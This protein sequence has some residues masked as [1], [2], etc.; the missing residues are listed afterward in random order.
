MIMEMCEFDLVLDFDRR[1]VCS[2]SVVVSS[3]GFAV[4]G[5]GG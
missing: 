5:K 1:M 3:L 2:C 4:D